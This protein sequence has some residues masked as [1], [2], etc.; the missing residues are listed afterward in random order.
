MDPVSSSCQQQDFNVTINRLE[1]YYNNPEKMA[2]HI[3]AALLEHRIIPMNVFTF[4]KR[5]WSKIQYSLDETG[6]SQMTNYQEFNYN[7]NKL[8]DNK[9]S[10]FYQV[11]SFQTPQA[12]IKVHLKCD[13]DV[14]RKQIHIIGYGNTSV[15]QIE[16][17]S[18]VQYQN[19]KKAISACHFLNKLNQCQKCRIVSVNV[20]P[21]GFCEYC[22]NKAAFVIQSRWREC[23][24]NPE[25][26]IC[27]KRLLNEFQDMSV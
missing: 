24:S 2:Y 17:T 14:Y 26:N 13:K 4:I 18:G 16:N 19:I 27:R 7:L 8:I 12:T 20:S 22:R 25:Y 23:I 10:W 11:G 5:L 1:D 3:F 21:N 9:W 6:E 15:F